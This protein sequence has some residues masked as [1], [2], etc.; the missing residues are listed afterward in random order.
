M[1]FEPNLQKRAADF[2]CRTI[3]A[4]LKPHY[5]P[6]SLADVILTQCAKGKPIDPEMCEIAELSADEYDQ[7]IAS[8]QT[9]ELKAYY[10]ECQQLLREII[11]VSR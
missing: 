9:T 2:L 4:E 10:T 3:P 6:G 1:P 8:A 7:A 11:K 5:V